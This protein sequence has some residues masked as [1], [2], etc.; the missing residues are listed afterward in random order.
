MVYDKGKNS[1]KKVLYHASLLVI[2]TFYLTLTI[3]LGYTAYL[4]YTHP[5]KYVEEVKYAS[6]KYGVEPL[7]VMSVIKVESNFNENAVSNKNAVG[8][9]QVK[10]QTAEYLYTMS[11]INYDLKNPKDNVNAGTYYIRYLVDKF[12]NIETALMAYNAGEGN[13]NKWLK[14]ERYSKD[15]KTLYN[16]PFKETE[17]YIVKFRKSFENYK[18]LYGNIVDKI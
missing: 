6:Q 11:G 15:G 10:P 13:V 8:L 2:F 4:K 7:L 12:E 18:N 16:V 5:L 9:M 1:F 17:N 14:D 3:L